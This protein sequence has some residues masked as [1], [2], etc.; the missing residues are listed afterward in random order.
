LPQNKAQN[1]R[2]S[3]VLEKL[4]EQKQQYVLRRHHVIESILT[5]TQ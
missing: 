2:E 3:T 4:F 1:D 5:L